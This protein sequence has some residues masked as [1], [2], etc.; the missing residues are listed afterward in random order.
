VWGSRAECVP[1]A[2]VAK[3]ELAKMPIPNGIFAR[4]SE[5]HSR[6]PGNSSPV[7]M[8]QH[9]SAFRLVCKVHGIVRLPVRLSEALCSA[10]ARDDSLH[11]T[12][13]S[14]SLAATE[15]MSCC[16]TWARPHFRGHR[17]LLQQVTPPL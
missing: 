15:C 13:L 3:V 9:G 11:V 10:H 17:S 1:H 8:R 5:G 14:L 16:Y 7:P 6:G 12:A 2:E 4:E